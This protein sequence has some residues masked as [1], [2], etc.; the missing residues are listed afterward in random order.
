MTPNGKIDR[1]MLP[2]YQPTVAFA[3]T[4]RSDGPSTPMQ[5]LVA[6]VWGELLGLASEQFGLRDNFLDLGGHSL[7]VMRAAAILE[8]RT[9]KRVGPRTFIFETLEQVAT[10][11]EDVAPTEATPVRGS[12]DEVRPATDQPNIVQPNAVQPSVVQPRQPSQSTSQKAAKLV[13]RV[14]SGLVRRD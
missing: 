4:T 13:G 10:Q 2:A 8:A 12:A 14:L 1:K 5:E 9:G 11:Y 6:S 3:G 7:L